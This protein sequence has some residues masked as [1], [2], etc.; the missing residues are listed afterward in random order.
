MLVEAPL[1][2]NSPAEVPMNTAHELSAEEA[3]RLADTATV[4]DLEDWARGAAVHGHVDLTDLVDV[5]DVLRS[6]SGPQASVVAAL[7]S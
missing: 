2:T 1:P 6:H 4:A 3:S 5:L 7:A